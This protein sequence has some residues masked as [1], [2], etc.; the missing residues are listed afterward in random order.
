MREAA[1][2]AQRF[3]DRAHAGRLIVACEI[4]R[5]LDAPLDVLQL[6]DQFDAV[7]HIEETHALE[8]WSAPAS[9]RPASRP[10]PV[11]GGV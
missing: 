8:P 6:A 1:T 11:H 10:R 9:G 2:R 5:T 4:A 7:I 3:R